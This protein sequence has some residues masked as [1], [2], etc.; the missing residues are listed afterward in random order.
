MTAPRTRLAWLLALVCGVAFVR[1]VVGTPAAIVLAAVAP[2]LGYTGLLLLLDRHEREP[3]GLMLGMLLWGAAVAA[4]LASALNDL[5]LSWTTARALVPILAAPLVEETAKG[6]G[7]LVLLG[8]VPHEI[9][10]TLDGL[11]YGAVIGIGF[12][13]TENLTY[14]TLAAVQGDDEGRDHVQAPRRRARGA[15]TA[16]QLGAA[17]RLCQRR[18]GYRIPHGM[19][20]ESQGDPANEAEPAGAR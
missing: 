12:A 15:R 18:R 1:T 11:V 13:M 20:T 16:R 5:V 2:A 19:V 17:E 14:F 6:L 9:D 4:P 8:L 7:L 10:D 3:F